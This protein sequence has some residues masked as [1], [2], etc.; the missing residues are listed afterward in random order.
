[1]PKSDYVAEG[2]RMDANKPFS[3]RP[4]QNS[5]LSPSNPE[6]HTL[7]P[8]DAAEYLSVSERT[9]HSLLKSG[10]IPYTKFRRAVLIRV[11]DLETFLD[12]HTQRGGQSQ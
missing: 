5:I 11:S 6:R 2:I 10:E 7:R 8:R 9:L 3:S 1:M 4:P 12:R